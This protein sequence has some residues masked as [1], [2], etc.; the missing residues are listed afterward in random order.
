[1]IVGRTPFL[2]VG[3]NFFHFLV[4]LLN[5]KGFKSFGLFQ[6]EDFGLV[7][8]GLLKMLC[9]ERW[10]L[11]LN[12]GQLDQ[13]FLIFTLDRFERDRL[14]LPIRPLEYSASPFD[15]VVLY[16]LKIHVF[17]KFSVYLLSS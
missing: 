5:G 2:P 4:V 15:L 9:V 6:V 1:M 13:Y 8:N 12:S 17:L 7:D 3:S 10:V 11:A 14:H 16:I